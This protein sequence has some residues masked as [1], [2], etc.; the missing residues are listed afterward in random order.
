LS[1]PPPLTPELLDPHQDAEYAPNFLKDGSYRPW[2]HLYDPAVRSSVQDAYAFNI[3]VGSEQ[4][5]REL[6]RIARMG[7]TEIHMAT[8][9]HGTEIGGLQAEA[10]FFRVDEAKADSIMEDNPGLKIIL[11]DMGDPVQASSFDALQAQAAKGELPGGA[12]F[13]AFCFSRTRVQDAEP[14][15]APPYDTVEVLDVGTQESLAY[16]RAGLAVGFGALS[17]YSGAHDPNEALGALKITGGAAQIM[18]GA[19]SAVGYAID[20]INAVRI[21]STLETVGGH[22]VAPLAVVDVLRDMRQDLGRPMEPDQV[23][24]KGIDDTLKLAGVIYPEAALAAVAVKF[25]LEPVAEKTS[26][27]L[28]PMFQ[29]AISEAY[30]IPVQYIRGMW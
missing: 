25:G 2:D 9:T 15:P 26:E 27:Y 18:G 29:G 11:Y 4:V 19:S 30:G 1:G 10:L 28:T 8:G 5:G 23:L 6:N 7:Y 13:A 3:H 17:V 22:V 14:G 21:G 20:S 12:T 16:A 24:F